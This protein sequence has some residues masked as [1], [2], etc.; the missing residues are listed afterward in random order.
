MAREL[1]AAPQA[2]VYARIGTCTQEFGTLASWL[3]DVL[4]VLTGNLD[5]E[6]GA[7]FPLAAAGQRN[8]S[9][10]AGSG[11]GVRF[12]R[13]Q[14]RVRGLPEAYGELPVA[15]PGRG[16]RHPRR[17]TGARA[18]DRRRQ[19]GRV[20][21]QHRPARERD[22]GARLHAGGRHLRERDDSP[23][24][25]DPA[26]GRSRSRS[27]TTTWR[28]TSSPCATWRTTRRPVFELGRSGRVGGLPAAGRR[29]GRAGAG[30]RPRRARRPGHLHAGQREVG[31]AGSRVAGREP[32]ELLEALE[33]RRGPERVL[34]FMLRVGP[35]GDGFGA[36]PEGLTLDV[37]ESS[38][39]G[40][41]L[42]PHRERVPEVLR[43]PSG[44]IELAPGGDRGR[45]RAPARGSGAR[46]QRRPGADRPAPAALEQ[47][48]DAQPAGARE[49]QGPLHAARPP[50]RRRAARPR[51]RRPG[52][53]Q[54][55]GGPDRGAGRGDRRHH[56]R[57]RVD[58][59]R[60]GPRRA[61]R[62]DG[63]GQRATPA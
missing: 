48:V 26:R 2:A 59:A 53:D 4:N 54:L 56:A 28:S 34:D 44:R 38:P 36:E 18:G 33:P 40:V 52:G 32:A 47:L 39:H 22:R 43:T 63:R 19:P 37:L 57:R 46:A 21:A 42:G 35:Y 9:G 29:R 55:G 41:D 7:M 6:G 25:R 62:E 13:W 30:R 60:L 5:R 23:R 50:R 31:D 8:A 1:A 14:S 15:V 61:R 17:G 27:R 24:R 12:G 3:V 58:P 20:H 49:G 45:R 10:A 16:D 51:G 11:R